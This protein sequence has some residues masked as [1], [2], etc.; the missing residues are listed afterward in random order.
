M[1]GEGGGSASTT[2]PARLFF[3]P[4]RGCG[5]GGIPSCPRGEAERPQP[6]RAG[7]CGR[8]GPHSHPRLSLAAFLGRAGMSEEGFVTRSSM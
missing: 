3:F 1:R 7:E 8:A 4:H 2:S 6:L 5:E